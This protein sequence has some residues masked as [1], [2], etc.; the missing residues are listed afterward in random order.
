MIYQ[1][2]WQSLENSTLNQ[3]AG[4]VVRRIKPHAVCDLFLAIAQ[5][6]KQH[7]FQIRLATVAP[8]VVAHLPSA[9]G[10]DISVHHPKN[11]Q[12]S[13][14]IQLA[15]KESR[16][17]HIFDI[18][19]H[20]IA[21]IIGRSQSEEAATTAFIGRL[22]HWQKFLEQADPNGLSREAQQG[23][24]GE[25]WFLRER[26]ISLLGLLPALSAWTG[27][28]GSNQ[29]FQMQLCAVEVKTTGTKEP[30]Q[31]IIQ[32]ERQLDDTGLVA[33]FLFHLALEVREKTGESL[34]EMIDSL[35]LL[36]AADLVALDIFEDRILDVGF[37]QSQ[38]PQYEKIGYTIR[39]TT[40]FRVGY[41]F[42]RVV[43]AD[44]KP[45]VGNIH[46]SIAV[47]ECRHF[48]VN[49]GDLKTQLIGLNYG[50]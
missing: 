27:P 12:H 28:E 34:I 2:I 25:L 21:E 19:I 49:D 50:E 32:S 29:D 37:I 45:G 40:L 47:A 44:L 22:R 14:T 7:L 46:Y 13:V 4:Y 33:L 48:A 8:A 38:A 6:S 41:T 39:H 23:L 24:Y 20:D 15:L 3:P 1:G 26:L 36:L 11:G 16:F 10:L 5:P 43:G 35:R 31:M 18:L 30:Q 42:P 9:R 17:E